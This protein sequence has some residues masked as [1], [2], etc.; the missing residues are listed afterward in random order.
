MVLKEVA[1]P[2]AGVSG[3]L[4][5]SR[6]ARAPPHELGGGS[7]VPVPV[8]GIFLWPQNQG[9]EIHTYIHIYI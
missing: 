8:L 5:G 1:A 7:C 4:P 3:P 2:A 9:A 6:P